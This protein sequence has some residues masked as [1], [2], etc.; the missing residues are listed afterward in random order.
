MTNQP[1]A[2]VIADS[3]TSE[4]FRLTTVEATC[5]RPV[6]AE[7]NTHCVLCLA[8][9]AM[10]EFDMPAG[11]RPGK[12]SHRRVFKMRLDEFVDKW[13]NGS[14]PRRNKGGTGFNRQP[15]QERLRRMRIR[16][17]NEVTGLIQTSTVTDAIMSGVKPVFELRAGKFSV[18]GSADHRIY[19]PN[20][21]RTIGQLSPG[22][23]IVVRRLGKRKED[24]V[25]PDRLRKIGGVWRSQWQR[26]K[27]S[28]LLEIYGGCTK[29]GGTDD[30][31]VHHII[32]VHI[33]PSLAFVDDNVTL[34]CED[35]HIDNHRSQGWQGGT[36]LYGDAVT[37]DEV[38]RRGDEM[39]YDIEVAGEYPN[40]VANGIVVHNSRN[41]AS[42]RAIPIE[43]NLKRFT[44]EF[45]YPAAWGAERPGMQPGPPLEGPALAKAQ[46]LW[47]DLADKVAG[48]IQGYIENNPLKNKDGNDIPD[49]V[50][51]HKSLLNRWLEVGLSQTQ[52]ISAT[53][54]DGYFW[55]R[56]HEAADPNIRAM[57]EAIQ[58]A[59]EESEPQLL[60]P[61]EWHLPYFGNNGGAGNQDWED[62]LGRVS[63]EDSAWTLAKQISAGRT[64]RVSYLT[65]NGR[66]E[67]DKDLDLYV[68]LADRSEEPQNPPHASPLEHIATPW[69]ENQQMVVMP[70]GKK[71]GPLPKLGKF[72]GWWQFRH[73]ELAF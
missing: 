19:T 61:G 33:D 73:Q 4:G 36:Y 9:D 70:N 62:V 5:W 21:W 39:T 8:G 6:L 2:K 14:A 45:M 7:Q 1:G 60:Q 11:N 57:A 34:L 30:L 64:A 20:G 52:V 12:E 37:L 63:E 49:A 58:K 44:D 10:L 71:M 48:L 17:L 35:C 22:D 56:C 41:S 23:E 66:R 18:A 50:R 42:S 32:P 31:Q 46:T 68:R 29:C 59:R 51:L 38:V 40:F 54:W 26:Q 65:Q 3:I 53:S 47:D 72:V 16:Q 27:R 28:E 69:P 15:V 24:L 25:D 43:K 67:I 13:H 55:Q